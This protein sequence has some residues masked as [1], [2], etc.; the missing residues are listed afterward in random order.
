MPAKAVTV[1]DMRERVTLQAATDTTDAIG[2]L[3]R[4]WTDVATV[5]AR[6]EEMSAREQYHREQIQSSANF[7]VTIRY[8]ADVTTKNRVIWRGRRFEIVGRPNLDERRRF[9]RLACE[10]LFSP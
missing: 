2:G 3:V 7:A 6:V 10:E 1:G 5:W 8:R 9:M 4:S